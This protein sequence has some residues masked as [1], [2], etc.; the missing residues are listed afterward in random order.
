MVPKWDPNLE[1]CKSISAIC[2]K[3]DFWGFEPQTWCLLPFCENGPNPVRFPAYLDPGLVAEQ[4]P[5]LL[6]LMESEII[7]Y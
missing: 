6:A 3:M 7:H 1:Y 5:S 4:P 2:P